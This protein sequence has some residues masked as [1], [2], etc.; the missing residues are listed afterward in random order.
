MTVQSEKTMGTFGLGAAI[1]GGGF[2]LMV[3]LATGMSNVPDRSLLYVALPAPVAGFLVST[4]VLF[5][6][7]R[8]GRLR[9]RLAVVLPA[10]VISAGV[11]FLVVA[12][13]RSYP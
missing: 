4:W 10:A 11:I 12:A 2:G 13:W 7:Y 3:L 6:A 9:G 1:V 8:G 5:S